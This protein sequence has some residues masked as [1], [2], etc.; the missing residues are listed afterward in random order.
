M[1]G[2]GGGAR[3]EGGRG[4]GALTPLPRQ[5]PDVLKQFTKAAIKSQP[6]NLHLWA[7]QYF[8]A[9]AAG[10]LPGTSSRAADGAAPPAP[11]GRPL[12]QLASRLSFAATVD[13]EALKG[14]WAEVGL[15]EDALVG[16]FI[17][18]GDVGQEMDVNEV[19]ILAAATAV[20]E[21]DSAAAYAE[22]VANF[23]DCLSE[24]GLAPKLSSVAAAARYFASRD[25]DVADAAVFI[26]GALTDALG[27]EGAVVTAADVRKAYESGVVKDAPAEEE[28]AAAL[29]IQAQFRGYQARCRVAEMKR[30]SPDSVDMDDPA[31]EDAATT[32]QSAFRGYQARKEIKAQSMQA[33]FDPEDEELQHAAETI[34]ANFK[35]FKVRKQLSQTKNATPPPAEE[36]GEDAAP[37]S[38][39][40]AAKPEATEAGDAGDA[41]AATTEEDAAPAADEPAPAVEEVGAEEAK[42]AAEEAAPAAEEAT[43]AAEE[44]APAAEEVAPAA[45]EA[46]AED[47][48]PAAEKAAPAA[49]EAAPA[50]EEAAPAADEAAPAAEEAAPVAEEAAP[51]ADEAAPAADEAAPAAD[52]A[53]KAEE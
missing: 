22:T 25:A 6:A 17:V 15:S 52:E 50:A 33:Q 14:V 20:Q 5:L 37:A 45:E 48:T 47:A 28:E 13:R 21:E 7:A 34:Q 4:T 3:G 11:A 41:P 1:R 51:A 30:D 38:D 44:A 43:P 26:V 27:D 16:L 40:P 39:E 49:E 8:E 24:A 53:P 31:L 9:L 2:G 18:A 32:V 36:G 12:V 29:R 46:G 35:G 42:P 23:V 10:R 19:L